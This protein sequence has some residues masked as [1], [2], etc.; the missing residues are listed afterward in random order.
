M[1]FLTQI[2]VVDCKLPI[3][4]LC[5]CMLVNIPRTKVL[6]QDYYFITKVVSFLNLL[7]CFTLDC[8]LIRHKPVLMAVDFSC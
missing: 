3:L 6:K 5:S 2:I 8:R 1:E 4:R 7:I